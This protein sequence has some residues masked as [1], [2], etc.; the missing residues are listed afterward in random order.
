MN[1]G[2]GTAWLTCGILEALSIFDV[3]VYVERLV[4]GCGTFILLVLSSFL[5]NQRFLELRPMKV[6]IAFTN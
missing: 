2:G 3:T 1:V 4:D 5:N 6:E